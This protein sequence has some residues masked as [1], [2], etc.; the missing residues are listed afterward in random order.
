MPGATQGAL[1]QETEKSPCSH[2]VESN[3]VRD[4]I[5]TPSVALDDLGAR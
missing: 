1:P 3:A 2:E 5:G 4:V